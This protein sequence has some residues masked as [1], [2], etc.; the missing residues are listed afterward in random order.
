M[1]WLDNF[2]NKLSKDLKKDF[3]THV[4]VLKPTDFF[5]DKSKVKRLLISDIKTSFDYFFKD[6][7][8]KGLYL[9]TKAAKGIIIYKSDNYSTDDYQ[10][11]IDF[12]KE[13]LVSFYYKN[14][15]AHRTYEESTKVKKCLEML[16][17]KPPRP[18]SFKEQYDQQFGQV[19][20]EH[21]IQDGQTV[22][23]KVLCTYY[24]GRNYT[25]PYTFDNFMESIFGE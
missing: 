14:S 1:D 19:L 3:I 7:I 22:S 25:D 24:S 2:I 10:N 4:D 18:T 12:I 15:V 8:L 20:V 21:K 23:F 11:L 6:T 5:G 9:D 13:K 17:M 16:Y